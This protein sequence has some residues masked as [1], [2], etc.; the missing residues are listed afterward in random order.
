LQQTYKTRIEKLEKQVAEFVESGRLLNAAY[1][2]SVKEL[3]DLKVAEAKLQLKIEALEAQVIS[4]KSQ[5]K[6][7][8]EELTKTKKK[9]AAARKREVITG[10]IGVAVLIIKL[11]LL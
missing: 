1:I 5:L 10:A 6:A 11:G 3:S 7:K 2:A 9:L 4:L 8:D